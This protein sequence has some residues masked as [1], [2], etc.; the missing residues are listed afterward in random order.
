MAAIWHETMKMG[1][2]G[3]R[4]APSVQDRNEANLGTQMSGIGSDPAQG[5]GSRPEKDGVDGLLVLVGDGLELG[6]QCEDD[7]E[8]GHRQKRAFAC[9]DPVA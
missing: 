2:K 1:M 7:V 8:I 9:G 6:R 3:Q 4:L 5:L